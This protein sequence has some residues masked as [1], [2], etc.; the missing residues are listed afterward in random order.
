M[1]AINFESFILSK[2][3]AHLEAPMNDSHSSIKPKN[4]S[5]IQVIKILRKIVS[6]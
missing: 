6:L 1:V 2:F 4:Q 5:M 3:Q